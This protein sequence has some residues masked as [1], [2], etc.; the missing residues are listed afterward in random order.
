MKFINERAPKVKEKGLLARLHPVSSPRLKTLAMASL[1]GKIFG[2]SPRGQSTRRGESSA[3]G[4]LRDQ[5][6]L[7]IRRTGVP[8]KS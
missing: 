4:E 2:A 5:L 8:W 7:T 6:F 3:S 1:A